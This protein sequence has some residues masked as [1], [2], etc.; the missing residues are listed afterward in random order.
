[1]RIAKPERV[2]TPSYYP[3]LEVVL[4]TL[5]A[6][7]VVQL[8]RMPTH[9]WA[10]AI[11]LETLLFVATPIVLFVFFVRR[12][13]GQADRSKDKSTVHILQCGAFA[14]ALL[15]IAVQWVSRQ[16]GL[17]DAYE[18]VALLMLQVVSWYLAVFSRF[19][20]FNKTAFLLSGSLVLFVCFMADNMI[21]LVAASFYGIIALWWLLGNYWNRLQQK[22]LD[23]QSTTLPV[24]AFAILLVLVVLTAVGGLA[25]LVVPEDSTLLTRGFSPFSGGQLGTQNDFARRGVGDG[26]MLMAGKNATTSGAVESDQFIEDHKPSIYDITSDTYEGPV[27]IRRQRNRA[28]AIEA[29]AKHVER[30]I[31]SELAGKTFRT[32][33]E[34][35]ETEQRDLESKKTDALFFVEGSVPAR[36]AVDTFQNF[37]GWDWSK[38]SAEANAIQCPPISVQTHAGKPWYVV[39]KVE[40]AYLPTTR[41][42]RIKIMRL[43]TTTLPASP[44]LKAWHI[45]RV[46]NPSLFSWNENA[47]VCIDGDSIPPQTPIDVVSQVPNYH[48]LRRAESLHRVNR[49]SPLWVDS[50]SSTNGDN[51]AR[52]RVSIASADEANSSPYLQIP[53]NETKGRVAELAKE[54]TAGHSGGWNQI[55][56][57]VNRLRTEYT[58]STSMVAKSDGTDS[59]ASFLDQK[60]GP[61]YLFAT[62]AI[63]LL[64]AAGYQTRL[65]TGFLIEKKHY[66]RVANQ[67]T[68]TAENL[69]MWPEV[70]LDGWHW[71]PVEPTPGYPIPFSHQT[72]GQR[73]MAKLTALIGWITR[74]PFLSTGFAVAG[75]LLVYFRCELVALIGWLA[76]LFAGSFVP[77]QR[78]VFTRKLIDLRFWAAG[79]PRPKFKPIP[80]W[81]AQVDRSAGHEFYRFWLMDRYRSEPIETTR[82]AEVA[83][84]CRQAA[85][86]FSFQQIKSHVRRSK[87]R[88]EA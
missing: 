35:K 20:S 3:N 29:V 45:D 77:K 71:I 60:G 75:C 44:L 47:M 84:A 49:A 50:D 68:V 22:S 62:T 6:C 10:T 57:I 55:E 11:W 23:A 52:T 48:V 85:S 56:A 39:R 86:A 5:L 13:A 79:L 83:A 9:G 64:R 36:F 67:S 30:V 66:D 74:H 34:P 43:T 61:S 59:V 27:K 28:V 82:R 63:Q 17:G 8:F 78:L 26:N 25:W 12:L 41:P 4:M 88:V 87:L 14:M 53:D 46:D 73:L 40:R 31:E 58:H 54:W 15:V 2:V 42:H 80:E 24:N 81:F 69:H 72:L 33:R 1:M 76:W 38:I 70:C 32:I 37:D 21:V 16:C 51:A 7:L 18:I 19:G 65:R